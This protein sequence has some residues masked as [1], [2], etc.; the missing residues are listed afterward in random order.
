M[1]Y[2]DTFTGIGTA[3]LA[4]G[5]LGW[6]CIGHAETDKF[7]S[8]VLKARFPGVHN[9]G[10]VTQFR[11]W[12]ELAIDLLSGGTPCQSFSTAGLRRGLADPRGSLML[13]YL[14]M[15]ARYRPRWLVWENVPG[16]FPVGAG[17]AFATLLQGLDE[18]GYSCAWRVL[19]TQFVRVPLFPRALPQQRRRIFLVGYLGNW[20]YPAEVLF[21]RQSMRGDRPPRREA[22]EGIAP[23]TGADLESFGFVSGAVT[24]KWAK[25]SGGPAG[26]EAYN[27]VISFDS[28]RAGPM[29]EG[30]APTLR[31]MN[32]DQTHSNAG[33]QLAISQA[34]RVRRLTPRECERLQGL[35]DDWTDIPWRG[36]PHAPDGP[37]YRAI[38]NAWSLNSILWIAS[39]IDAI[40]KRIEVAA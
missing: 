12:P 34:G 16:V 40:E 13:T 9:Y 38:G 6:D 22:G 17:R 33:G 36:K 23:D 7:A 27:L 11:D 31:A 32:Y 26:D 24:S 1:R 4:Y 3:S 5:S 2:L 37:R 8:A 25:Y 21:E 19:D 28:K 10:N 18:L 35:P 14:A 29:H 15:A 39:R 20:T 30:L